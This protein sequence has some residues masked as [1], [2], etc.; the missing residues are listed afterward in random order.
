MHLSVAYQDGHA[1]NRLERVYEAREVDKEAKFQN[2][3]AAVK[4]CTKL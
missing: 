2:L 1:T 3:S 4:K